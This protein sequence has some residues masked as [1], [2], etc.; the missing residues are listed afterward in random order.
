MLPIYL[1]EEELIGICLC[2]IDSDDS[3]EDEDEDED[4]DDEE[5]VQRTSI[6]SLIDSEKHDWKPKSW[7]EGSS[8]RHVR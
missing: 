6:K 1:T 3:S 2:V 4:G 5:N 7:A 8:K